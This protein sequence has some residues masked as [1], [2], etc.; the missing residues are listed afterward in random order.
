MTKTLPPTLARWVYGLV[1]CGSVGSLLIPREG[2]AHSQVEAV[3]SSIPSSPDT[4]VYASTDDDPIDRGGSTELA[5]VFCLKADHGGT[6]MLRCSASGIACVSIKRHPYKADSGM[7]QLFACNDLTLGW[8]CDY[9]FPNGD[10]CHTTH[11]SPF[12]DTC[13]YTGND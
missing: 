4:H 1:A 7:G 6:C 8:M 10:S 5:K 11:G 2:V 12:P 9:A 13:T 3:G